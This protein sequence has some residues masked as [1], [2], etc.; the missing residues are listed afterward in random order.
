MLARTSAKAE[1]LAERIA[2]L[3]P[4]FTILRPEGDGPFPIVIMLHGCG[5]RRDFLDKYAAAALGAGGAVVIVDSFA[6]RGISRPAAIA[7][8]CTGLAFR[9]RE[10]AGDLYAAAAWARAQPWADRERLIAAGWSHGGWTVLDAL[11]LH[12][13]REMAAATGLDDLPDE[14]LAGVRAAFIAYPYA[15][16]ASLVGRRPWRR[17]IDAV[18]IIAGRDYIVGAATPRAA[19]ARQRAL[20]ARLEILEFAAATHAFEETDG[21]DPRIR[22]SAEHSARAEALL[23]ALVARVRA[24]D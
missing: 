16:I 18:A 19:L 24:S 20:G 14:P 23:A 3:E 11:A 9:G 15:G 13:G 17:D 21:Q 7:T 4:C 6:A 2:L 10:R 12:K 1:T 5:G 8:I 22:Y